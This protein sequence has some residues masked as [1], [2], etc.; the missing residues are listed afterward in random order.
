MIAH[1]HLAGLEQ[2][3]ALAESSRTR[4]EM[5]RRAHLF[6]PL[7]ALDVLFQKEVINEETH[8]PRDD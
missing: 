3:L 4:S 8:L 6:V 2:Q 7:L 1:L 5:R